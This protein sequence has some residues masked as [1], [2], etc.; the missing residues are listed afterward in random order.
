[1]ATSTARRTVRITVVIVCALAMVGLVG[2]IVRQSASTNSTAADLVRHESDGATIMHPILSLIGNLVA[3]QSSAVRG[4]P[5]NAAGLEKSLAGVAE[6]DSEYGPTLQ[7]TEGLADLTTMVRAAIAKKVTGHAAYDTYSGLVTLAVALLRHTGDTSHLSHDPELDSY[8]V[9]D[10]AIVRLPDAQVYSSRAA[11]LVSLS[12]GKELTGED[13]VRAAVARFGVSAAAEQVSAGLTQSVEF[14]SRSSLGGNIA[15]RLDAFMAAAGAFAPPT[16]LPQL[17][18]PGAD[19][20]QLAANARRVSAAA[21][22]LA[23]L[24]LSELQ[25]LLDQR[26]ADLNGQWRFTATAAGLAGLAGLVMIWVLL[27][28]RPRGSYVEG[29]DPGRDEVS[30]SSVTGAQ[31]LLD[32]EELVHVGRAVRPRARGRDHAF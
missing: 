1:M 15:Q 14:T 21:A 17:V 11:D 24:L 5:V 22:P 18:D 2:A 10:A 20:T 9:M 12:G 28:G 4:E 32:S 16:M 30:L 19:A 23:H 8:Y 31:D 3:A 27:V 7:T 25:A 6:L 13:A 29:P 26:L